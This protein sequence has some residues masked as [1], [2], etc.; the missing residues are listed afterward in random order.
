MQN[1]FWKIKI[2]DNNLGTKNSNKNYFIIKNARSFMNNCSHYQAT[3]TMI[4]VTIF[5]YIKRLR[6]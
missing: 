1:A 5:F 4:N 2:T 6:I 3:N